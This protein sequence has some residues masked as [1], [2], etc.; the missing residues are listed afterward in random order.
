MEKNDQAAPVVSVCTGG[1]ELNV[2]PQALQDLCEIKELSRVYIDSI[3]R[4]MKKV[5]EMGTGDSGTDK[6]E[7]FYMISSLQD[8]K[9]HYKKIANLQLLRN[10]EEVEPLE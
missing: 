3:N 4:M 5:V 2:T 10:G 9:E 7:F 8:F 6:T 1:I